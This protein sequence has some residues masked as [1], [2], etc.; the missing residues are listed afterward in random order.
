MRY[1][2]FFA[3]S[4]KLDPSR[5][6]SEVLRFCSLPSTTTVLVFSI[7]LWNQSYP[8]N[9]FSLSLIALVTMVDVHPRLASFASHPPT[10]PRQRSNDKAKSVFD[11]IQLADITH[12]LFPNTPN[13]SPSSSA[14]KCGDYSER[15]S[16]RVGF[17]PWTKYHKPPSNNSKSYGLD[18][19]M[20]ILPPSKDCKSSKSI[21]KRHSNASTPR[22]ASDLPPLGLG[23]DISAMLES[24]LQHLESHSRSS[25]VD[26]YSALLGCL[27]AY[28]DVPGPE[29]LSQKLSDLL[30]YIRRDILA[31]NEGADS[32]DTQ[33]VSQA[34]KLLMVFVSTSGLA[35]SIPDDFYS[36]IVEQSISNLEDRA[37]PKILVIHYLQLLTQESLSNQ[38]MQTDRANRLMLALDG[39]VSKIKGNRIVG[40]RL[41]VYKRLLTQT[42]ST[43]VTCA[44]T[45]VDHLISGMLSTFKDI[46]FRAIAFGTEASLLLGTIRSVSQVFVDTLNRESPEGRKVVDFLA[47]RLTEMTDDKDE[48]I[49][50]PQIWSIVILFLRGRKRQLEAWEHLKPWLFIIQKC[51]NSSDAKIKY[52]ANLAWNRLIF[53]INLDS[54]TSSSMIKM[55]RQPIVPQLERRIDLK[56]SK[57]SKNAKQIARS[58]YCTLLYYAFRPSATHA[59]Y[60]QYWEEYVSQ[61]LPSSPSNSDPDLSHSCNILAALFSSK[62]PKVWDENRANTNC[63]ITPEELPC[64]DPKWIRIRAPVI[65]TVFEKLF[66]TAVWQPE[67]KVDAPILIAWRS[68]GTAIGEAS[69][70]EV[71]T[72][73]ETMTAIA[74][75]L[76]AIKRFWQQD[77]QKKGGQEVFYL[78]EK[79]GCLFNE[80]ASKIG[81]IPFNEKRLTQSFQNSYEAAETP[82]GRCNRQQ[83]P[84]R[85]PVLSFL[86]LL[87]SSLEDHQITKNYTDIVEHLVNTSICSTATRRTQIGI[88]QDFTHL[89]SFG[90]RPDSKA[91]RILWQHIAKAAAF[92]FVSSKATDAHDDSPPS[93]GHDYRDAVKILDVALSLR[94]TEAIMDWKS[95]GN[96]LIHSLV[97]EVGTDGVTIILT[98]PLA[99]SICRLHPIGCDDFLIQSAVFLLRTARWPQSRK[100]TE[101]TRKL[102]WGVTSMPTKSTSIDLLDQLYL[103]ANSLLISSYTALKSI[104]S[105]SVADLILAITSLISSC[106]SS[107][108]VDFLKQIHPGAAL[109][110]KDDKGLVPISGPGDGLPNLEPAVSSN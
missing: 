31:K 63:P 75:I 102:L 73:M 6:F 99:A 29:A 72:S 49:H 70:K 9:A 80:A 36:F 57:P 79:V 85:S 53:T 87:A 13:D 76:N 47:S 108:K 41:M 46:R 44:E 55:L 91:K 88:L 104:P 68:F 20:K 78:I 97:E 48:G 65:L 30:N 10:P 35:G 37:M 27:S 14:E 15:G 74:H 77:L 106:P 86:S 8:V 12:E 59:Q 89:L 66:Q 82:S 101:R 2:K 67:K 96:T 1:L 107:L 71:K 109:W 83:G 64:L 16:K 98:E 32:L 24:T 100:A 45:W 4:Q 25:R 105:S 84:L 28:D 69:S 62:Q 52:Q 50:V 92:A 43:M 58:S 5:A 90:S 22:P 60:D 42:K 19:Q 51:F 103:M 81:T 40:Q 56:A 3:F 11:N 39:V 61:T 26:A 33:L 7:T 21:L 38:H 23:G 34:L 93:I 110:I 94:S 54:S 18:D 17:S 95:L